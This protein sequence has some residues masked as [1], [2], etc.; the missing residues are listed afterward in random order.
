[1]RSGQRVKKAIEF[2]HLFCMPYLMI[3]QCRPC[4]MR[5][6][7]DDS[8]LGSKGCQVR[9]TACGHIWYQSAPESKNMLITVP[10]E[11]G[12]E[13]RGFSI[14]TRRILEF[15]LLC[16]VGIS[17]FYLGRQSLYTLGPWVDGWTELMLNHKKSLKLE[18]TS[19]AF[20]ST[21]EGKMVCRGSIRNLSDKTIVSP[22]I[23]LFLCEFD[24]SGKKTTLKRD[25]VLENI[26]ILSGQ[27][28]TF[29]LEFPQSNCSSITASIS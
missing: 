19:F 8:V 22:K 17:S 18:L 11:S 3:V 26:Q 20:Q 23:Q 14:G 16:I 12:K 29:S 9:C 4:K 21:D 27:S 2:Y 28:Q 15:F 5:Y 6:H 13:Q 10:Q 1:M 7:L 24:S 25:H